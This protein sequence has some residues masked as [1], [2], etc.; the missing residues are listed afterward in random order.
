VKK[1][2]I[3]S[4]GLSFTG[5]DDTGFAICKKTHQL[6]YTVRGLM[7]TCCA[8]PVGELDPE[9]NRHSCVVYG[10]K[11]YH[12]GGSTRRSQGAVIDPLG[13]Y[14]KAR[15]RV[16]DEKG[17]EWILQAGNHHRYNLDREEEVAQFKMRLMFDEMVR[18]LAEH[19]S[20]F[21]NS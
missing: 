8:L 13:F 20:L 1:S 15:Q 12:Q 18:Y 6:G 5:D 7:P 17:A 4:N 9:M 2:F 14:N 11:I 10:N 3:E 16:Y 21:T 19:D